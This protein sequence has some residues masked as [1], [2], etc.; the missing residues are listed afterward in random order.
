MPPWYALGMTRREMLVAALAAPR[1]GA[2]RIE[3]I[4][5]RVIWNGR[6]TGTTWFMPRVT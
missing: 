2:V 6:Q 3:R 4:E 1:A 5:R